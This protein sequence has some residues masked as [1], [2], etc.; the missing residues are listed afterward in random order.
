MRR[1]LVISAVLAGLAVQ[2][3]ANEGLDVLP[4][5]KT[6]AVTAAAVAVPAKNVE[7]PFR[8]ARDPLP[9]LLP[10]EEQD[11]RGLRGACDAT[12]TALCY[13]LAD[14]RIVYRPARKYMPQFEGL[15]AE[16][17]SLRQDRL[18]LKYSFR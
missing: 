17:V 1:S 8:I 7:A 4:R 18:I 10:R 12:T 11:R 2:A 13:D 16:S 15:R 5:T 14:H 3:Q 6:M 9:E